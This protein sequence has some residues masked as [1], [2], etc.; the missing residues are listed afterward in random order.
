MMRSRLSLLLLILAA[1]CGGESGP[2]GD[3]GGG[4]VTVQI[5]KPAGSGD[6]QSGP[7]QDTL[8]AP[9]V[10]LVT[11]DGTPAAGR[12]VNFAAVAGSGIVVP[13]VDTTGVDGRA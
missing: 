3:G 13:T 6:A 10:V 12:V 8:P 4:G 11:E 2:S 9:I 1:A 7:I 5:Q